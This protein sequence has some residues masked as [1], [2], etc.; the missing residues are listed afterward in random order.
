MIDNE[1][2]IHQSASELDGT[3]YRQLAFNNVYLGV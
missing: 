3:Y 1:T 2:I